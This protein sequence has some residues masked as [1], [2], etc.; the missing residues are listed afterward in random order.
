MLKSF[1]WKNFGIDAVKSRG[2]SA[3]LLLTYFFWAFFF[4]VELRR[5]LPEHAGG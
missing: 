2:L 3:S 5:G 4:Q 1:N